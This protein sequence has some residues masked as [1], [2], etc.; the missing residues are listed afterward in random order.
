MR[1]LKPSFSRCWHVLAG[2]VIL[3]WP[4]HAY[5][6]EFEFLYINANEG[7]ASGGHA[8]IKFDNEVFHFQHVDPGL[9]RIYRDDFSAFRF[10]YGYRENRTILGHR[11]VV[12]DEVFQT[13]RDA[14]NRRLL[15]QNQQFDL[16]KALHDERQLLNDLKQLA[17]V[18]PRQAS[19]ATIELKA[20][21]YFANTFRLGAKN[22]GLQRDI[23]NNSA[24][25]TQL[26]QGIVDAYGASF[27]E[28]RRQQAVEELRALKPAK[29]LA[30]YAIAEDRFEP[31]G[32]S[33]AQHYQ[34]QLLNLAA[35][36]V[37]EAG[38]GPRPETLLTA[39]IPK[40]RLSPEAIRNL[41]KF[42][43][44]LFSD[45]IK[46]MQSKRSDWGYPLLVGM[47][48]LHALELSINSKQLVVLNRFRP[49]DND[50]KSISV[51]PDN[52]AAVVQFA[53]DSFNTAIDQLSET[54]KLD[55]RSYGELEVRAGTLLQIHA[56]LKPEQSFHLPSVDHTPS[57]AAKT[58]LIQL[59][60]SAKELDQY[61]SL[62]IAQSETY[63]EKL[64]ALY[65]Y[66]LL[67]RNCVTEIFRVIN[68][69][70]VKQS[71]SAY[72]APESIPQ[73]SQRLLGGYIN[74]GSL[75]I[76]PFVAFDQVGS[77]YR[78]GAS[79]RLPSYREQQMERLHD[80]NS[81][82]L[83]GLAESN[84]ITSSIYHWHGEDAAFLFFTEDA[85]WPR[86]LL[87]GL[88]LAMAVGQT[89]YGMLALPWDQG[90]NLQKSLKGIFVSVPELFFFNIRKGSF[91]QLIPITIRDSDAAQK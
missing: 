9:L 24:A 53:N 90:E 83:I 10:A 27:L 2:I 42:K 54:N 51:T 69:N 81:D 56:H 87:G 58:E 6:R 32:Y 82:I 72:V 18:S 67:G 57:L 52:A 44:T 85:T 76:I 74:N 89:L 48:R 60:L 28:E 7:S 13:L 29:S 59:P 23:S 79:Y 64:K 75:N 49:N 26:R 25:L 22:N 1:R 12:S 43:H 30:T 77:E 37:L 20:L 63:S 39:D 86:P 50:D 62:A 3:S 40:L 11:I 88:N 8:A 33:F 21:G 70:V 14:F 78:L 68:E 15:I 71:N 41:A 16:L 55:E 38:M 5:T 47:A 4:L 80:S 34:N 19:P 91:P 36:D 61:Q 17:E 84:T 45:L 65:R 31:N 73:T 46:L 66:E 35:L